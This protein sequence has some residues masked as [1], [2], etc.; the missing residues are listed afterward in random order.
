MNAGLHELPLVFFTVLAQSAVGATMMTAVY[1]LCGKSPSPQR[2]RV[3][4]LFF[5]PLLL[6]GL[7]FA[8]SVLHLG[9]PWRAFNAL[10]RIGSSALSNEI[11]A[12]AV[13]FLLTGIYWLLHMLKK[14]PVVLD[15]IWLLLLMISGIVF[16]YTMSSVY[17]ISTV[18]TWNNGYTA[19]AFMLTA[20]IAGFTLAYA[21]LRFGGVEPASLRP[22]LWLLLLALLLSVLLAILQV[23]SL[24]DIQT[25]VQK[26][27]ALIPHYSQMVMLKIMLLFAGLGLLYYSVRN[28]RLTALLLCSSVALML[29]AELL[30]RILFYGLHMTSGTAIAG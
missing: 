25:S 3:V 12:G 18:P 16:I 29:A 15:K 30:G 8:A 26:A 5:I 24:A 23:F 22:V 13:F 4:R 17:L 21:L 11:A 1:L 9:S 6:L 19:A 2:Y 7:G 14:M 10:N 27:T 28:P 20:V